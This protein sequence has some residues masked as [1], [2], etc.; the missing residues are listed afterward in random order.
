M[1]A[2]RRAI[3]TT[4]PGREQ[5]GGTEESMLERLL[6]RAVRRSKGHQ[7]A[8][9]LRRK[10]PHAAPAE[11]VRLLERRYLRRAALLGGGVGAAATV[12]AVGTGTAAVLT[13]GQVASFLISSATF[14]MAVATVHGVEVD[15]VERRRTL[16]AASLLGEEGAEMVTGQVGLG[17]L[18]WARTVLTKL[19]IA[20]IRAVNKMLTRRLVR[21]GFARGGALVLGRLVPFGVGAVI[22]YVGTRGMGQNVVDGV[23]EAFGP[24]PARFT[25]ELERAR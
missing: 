25:A 10:N 7:V 17:T 3:G 8:L 21:F 19:P 6:D 12:P 1:S 23:H 13:T 14:A 4:G 16:L 20:R 24:P 22:G 11:L 2:A 15:D 18:Y 5:A 9:E